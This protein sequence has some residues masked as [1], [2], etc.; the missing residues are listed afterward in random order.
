MH[1]IVKGFAPLVL[2]AVLASPLLVA[3]CAVH[4]RY[5]DP[6]HHDYH[7]IDGEVV[8]YGQWERETH[9]EHRELNR[10]SEAERKEYWEWRHKHQ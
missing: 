3:G 9:R 6:Y 1:R 4:A 2:A 5:Y 10:R 8:F 7:P